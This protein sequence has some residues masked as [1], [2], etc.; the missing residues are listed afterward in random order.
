[1]SYSVVNIAGVEGAGPGGA[2][3]FLRRE[4]GVEAFGVNWF[5]LPA[6]TEG[7]RHDETDSGQE[8]VNIVISGSG[9]Y[10]IDGEEVPIQA[11]MIF[12][13]DPETTRPTGRWA[14]RPD[15]DRGGRAAWQLRRPWAV[16]M[17]VRFVL[18]NLADSQTSIEELRRYL[19]DE[20]VD[21][22]EEVPGLLLKSWISDDVTERWGAIYIFE[23]T[24]ASEQPLP[25]RARELIGKDPD[26]VEI[27]DLEATVSVASQLARLGLA[28]ER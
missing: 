17:V 24:E 15:D 13:F 22:F 10:R 23:S 28:F 6:N 1:M 25:S 12:R 2:V 26:V 19:Q 3:K 21:A 5:E 4:L 27:F 20:A 14:G 9:T 18:W 8:E 7:R 11:P 16:L